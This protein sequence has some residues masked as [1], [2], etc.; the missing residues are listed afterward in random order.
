[1]GCVWL[2]PDISFPETEYIMFKLEEKKAAGT[3]PVPNGVPNEV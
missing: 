2:N 3:D 1:M